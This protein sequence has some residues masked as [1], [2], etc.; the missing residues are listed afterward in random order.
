MIL[1]KPDIRDQILDSASG[2]FSRFGFRKA[3][4]DEIAR[5][6]RKGKSS[7]YY[8]FTSKEEIYQAVIEKEAEQLRR[9][10]IKAISQASTPQEKLKD[11]ILTRMKTLQKV[12][13]FYDAIKNDYLSHLNFIEKI[14]VKYDREEI[15]LLQD[16]LQEGVDKQ[17]YR[18][19]NPE[20]TAKAIVIA[21]KGLEISLFW[22][23]KSR[24]AEESVDDLLHV[25]FY[26][27]LKR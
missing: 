9:E 4:M 18:I 23:G 17:V 6:M 21:M 22:S 5:S 19:E 15:H 1:S 16:I 25:L 20:Q 27:I 2:I 3:T 8:Y 10:L 12:T 7:I 14:R 24:D 11:Y 26:G 13:N